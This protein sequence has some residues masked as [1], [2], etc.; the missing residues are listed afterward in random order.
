MVNRKCF[1]FYKD[2]WYRKIKK[3]KLRRNKRKINTD[4]KLCY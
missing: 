1:R 3:K 2:F 4:K